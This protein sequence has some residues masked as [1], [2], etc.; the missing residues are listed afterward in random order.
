MLI[1]EKTYACSADPHNNFIRAQEI[2]YQLS[3]PIAAYDF[4]EDLTK[5]AVIV[6]EHRHGKSYPERVPDF[7]M[8]VAITIPDEKLCQS[9]KEL[10]DLRFKLNQQKAMIL[11]LKAQA[12][13][14]IILDWKRSPRLA[15]GV[16]QSLS[17]IHADLSYFPDL[18]DWYI[19]L[20]NI[21]AEYNLLMRSDAV[22][23]LN[24]ILLPRFCMLRSKIYLNFYI[25]VPEPA[26]RYL[27]VQCQFFISD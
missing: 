14:D 1:P 22:E 7:H 16:I 12:E 15:Q 26:Q 21:Q 8:E 20:P 5:K 13:D 27:Y 3:S 10:R 18:N 11:D 19:Q 6:F 23:N 25:S 24:T 4:K 9:T 2:E 17:H